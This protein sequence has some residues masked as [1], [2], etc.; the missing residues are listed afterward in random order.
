[1]AKLVS[2]TYGEALLGIAMEEKK[3]VSFL[4]EVEEIRKVLKENPDFDKMMLHPAIPKQEKLKCIERVFDGRVSDEIT[5][6]LKIVV[7]KERYRELPGIFQYFIDK[8]KEAQK[9]GIAYV[10]TAVELNN[11]QKKQVQDRLLATTD[12]RTM[13]MHYQVDKQIIGGMVIRIGD[14]VVDSSIRTRLDDL[15]KQLLQIQLG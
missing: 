13:E 7:Q 4:G 1:M 5:G 8:V 15:T 12:Y 6:F 3:E 9:I 11:K 14:R 10:T 2:K